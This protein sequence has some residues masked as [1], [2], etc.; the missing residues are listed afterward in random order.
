MDLYEGD[1][2]IA[3][4]RMQ[5]DDPSATGTSTGCYKIIGSDDTSG[6]DPDGQF[7]GGFFPTYM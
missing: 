7:I 3:A 4:L 2:L 1:M 6:D 5:S